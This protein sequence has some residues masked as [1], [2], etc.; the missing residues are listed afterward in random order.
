MSRT[1]LIELEAAAA[2]ARRGGFR[3]AARE[4]GMSSSAL[5]QAVATV[6]HM[7]GRQMG[8]GGRELVASV[9]VPPSRTG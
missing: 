7:I 2:V 9:G 4:L 5:S 8:P 3:A 1:S 6:E